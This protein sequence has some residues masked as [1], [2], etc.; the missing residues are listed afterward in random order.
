MM[1]V[2]SALAPLHRNLASQCFKDISKLI[3]FYVHIVK[4]INYSLKD[5]ILTSS[6][7]EKRELNLT[8]IIFSFGM[9]IM[10]VLL[11]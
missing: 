4:A 2:V 11:I 5:K 6:L 3:I 10:M 7:Q 9:S 8:G 1:S